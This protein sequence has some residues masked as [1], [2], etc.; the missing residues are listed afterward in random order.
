MEKLKIT[1]LGAGSSY[2][3]EI[4]EGLVHESE[5]LPV[6]EL[7]L[8]DSDPERLRVMT[9]FC[10]RFLSRL[11]SS[12]SLTSTTDR[13]EALCGARFVITQIRVGG[14]TQRIQDEKIPLKYGLVGQE[15]T[16][17]G[18]MLKA[19]RTIPVMLSIARDLEEINPQAWI[20]NYT[21]P[22]GLV[23][24]AV[25][26]YTRARIAGLCSGGLFPAWSAAKALGVPAEAVRYDYVGLNHLNF[27]YNFT[28]CGRPVRPEEFD[29][30]AQAAAHGPISADLI[31][32]L[33]LVPSPYL[34]YYYY[35]S[36]RIAEVRRQGRT[37]GEEVLELEK[38][39]FRA[40]ADETVDAKPAALQ[41]RGGGGYSQVALGV[42]KA[43]HNDQE[44]TVIVNV[45]NHGAL[46]GLPDQ[47]VVEIPCIVNAAGIRGLQM[48]EMPAS[49]W[50]LIAAVKNY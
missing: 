25:T 44:K 43:I 23:A 16:G 26:R 37:R 19:F 20:I 24:E 39:V 4:V 17:P 28:V 10:Q 27:A 41:K 40:Y 14:N 31:R 35:T 13:R 30:I 2:T 8:M 1:I 15:T 46:R 12:I 45:P 5:H 48:G 3:P 7:A 33:G 36:Q 32:V 18:G 38:E 9:A 50:G 49:V 42:M 6:G 21:N 34:Q 11:G 22:T 29:R 47:A